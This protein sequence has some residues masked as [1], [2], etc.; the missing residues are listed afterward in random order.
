MGVAAHQPAVP[1][2]WR[3]RSE[4]LV[5]TVKA[6]RMAWRDSFEADAG[7]TAPLCQKIQQG[8]GAEALSRQAARRRQG[9][10][11]RF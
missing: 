5:G 4:V 8:C 9:S 7:H 2:P 11:R 1:F 3:N 10:P 6:G